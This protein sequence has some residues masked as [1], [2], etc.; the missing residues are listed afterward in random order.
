MISTTFFVIAVLVI[1]IWVIIEIKRLKHKLLAIFLIG[2]I[3]FTYISFN[4]SL[5]NHELDLSTVPGIIEAGKIYTSWLSGVF[6]N[7]KSI[8]AYASKQNW[9]DYNRTNE[10]LNRTINEVEDE[11]KIE[12]V[13]VTSKV[14]DIWKKLEEI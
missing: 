2:I 7:V 6:V 1:A 14:D 10:N 8:T 9:K 4:M 5:K 13:N 3:L 11:G 12:I